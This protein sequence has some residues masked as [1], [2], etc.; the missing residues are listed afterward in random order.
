M[1]RPKLA[2]FKFASCDGCQLTLLDSD[3]EL[4]KIANDLDIVLFREATSRL[5]PGPYDLAILDGSITTERDRLKLLEIRERSRKLVSIGACATA[6]G[7]QALRNFR[8]HPELLSLVY[9]HP[10]FIDSL[11]T[12]TPIAAHV[13]VDFE[14]RG[15][16]VD[17]LELLE[18]IAALLLGRRPAISSHSVCLECKFHGIPCVV[19]AK[20]EPCLGPITH[21]GCGA[22]CPRHGRA[23]YGCFGPSDAPQTTTLSRYY[24]ARGVRA[25]PLTRAL[26]TFN[27]AAVP[28]QTEAT[29]LGGRR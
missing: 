24:L 25:E 29:R 16:P 19:V 6:G 8:H 14:L 23:C 9:A 11:E 27:A 7:I 22:L 10:E 28:F 13:P 1:P 20:A 17:R 5:D 4:L 12:S 18:V 15:C 21:A 2:V 3:A 26:S